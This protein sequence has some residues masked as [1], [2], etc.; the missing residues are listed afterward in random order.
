MGFCTGP[1]DKYPE[2]SPG[3]GSLREKNSRCPLKEIT[4]YF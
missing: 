1:S 4:I 2:K 3:S